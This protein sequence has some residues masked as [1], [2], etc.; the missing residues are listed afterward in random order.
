MAD[1]DDDIVDIGNDDLD[2]IVPTLVNKAVRMK[3]FEK[4]LD[5]VTIMYD[6][7]LKSKDHMKTLKNNIRYL[8]CTRVGVSITEKETTIHNAEKWIM[9]YN[10]FNS[11]REDLPV[12]TSAEFIFD[13]FPEKYYP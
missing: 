2:D 5:E 1:S 13:K 12:E 11:L 9:C 6:L 7:A 10:Q 3:R 8:L 4:V